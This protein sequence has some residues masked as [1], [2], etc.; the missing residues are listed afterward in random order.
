ME[1]VK[2][3]S[4]KAWKQIQDMSE[5][6]YIRA[7][8]DLPKY[9]KKAKEV[10]QKAYQRARKD[11]P[12][13]ADQVKKLSAKTYH[14][15]LVP[16]YHT[17]KE[18]V[19]EMIDSMPNEWKVGKDETYTQYFKRHFHPLLDALKESGIKGMEASRLAM[20]Q[21]GKAWNKHKKPKESQAYK[22]VKTEV[23]QAD[24]CFCGASEDG[25]MECLCG[26][27]NITMKKSQKKK[28]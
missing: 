20:S 18:L 4:K 5:K 23:N 9:A 7:K 3:H 8:S 13:Y 24:V 27:A 19:S 25:S 2:H 26:I 22:S 1:T 15:Y 21:V 17:A 14:D 10:S 6:A 12:V 28:E 16:A 11:L